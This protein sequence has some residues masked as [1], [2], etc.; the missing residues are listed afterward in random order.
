[1]AEPGR[2]DPALCR[3]VVVPG[4]RCEHGHAQAEAGVPTRP[5]IGDLACRLYLDASDDDRVAFAVQHV[6]GDA[7]GTGES[8]KRAGESLPTLT[9]R[10]IDLSATDR[11]VT[12]LILRE[13]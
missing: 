5:G 9:I 3:A 6:A 7:T 12:R 10:E 11:E 4:A 1:M 8:W 2:I 13:A